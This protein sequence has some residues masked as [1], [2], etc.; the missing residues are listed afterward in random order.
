MS[1]KSLIIIAMSF[2]S[3]LCSNAWGTETSEIDMPPMMPAKIGGTVMIN[4]SQ[5]TG[6]QGE[7]YHF[8]VTRPD[9][10]RFISS[11][12][13]NDTSEDTDGFN[14]FDC[15]GIYIP[16]YDQTVQ[17]DGAK[18]GDDAVIHVVYKDKP[19][20]EYTVKIPDGGQFKVGNSGSVTQIDLELEGPPVLHISPSSHNVSWMAGE[21][22]FDVTWLGVGTI[23]WEATVDSE[24]LEITSGS[25]GQNSDTIMVEYDPND[26]GVREGTIRIEIVDISARDSFTIEPQY[27]KVTQTC[28]CDVDADG[29]VEI[30]DVISMLKVLIGSEDSSLDV[31]SGSGSIGLKDIIYALDILST[32]EE[33]S[34]K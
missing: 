30:Q 15:Y 3:F 31:L 29:I 18:A 8:F 11:I 22:S 21:R 25:S 9:G 33:G 24:W 1:K 17:P 16:T 20:Y 6:E 10:S 4:G 7:D 5:I 14:D 32:H 27:V 26:G 23:E 34:A 19:E 12:N 28:L 13:A 2:L